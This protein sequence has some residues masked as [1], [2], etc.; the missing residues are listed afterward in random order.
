[1]DNRMTVME[2]YREIRKKGISHIYISQDY[3]Y[4]EY[5]N[6]ILIQ[7]FD[8]VIMKD[9]I[10]LYRRNIPY[11]T[12]ADCKNKV[13]ELGIEIDYIVIDKNQEKCRIINMKNIEVK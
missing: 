5:G 2:Y 10:E 9:S 4:D 11:T 12:I 6:F 13:K 7:L 3:A 1:M 8:V